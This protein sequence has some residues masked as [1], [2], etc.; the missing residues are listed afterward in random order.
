MGWAPVSQNSDLLEAIMLGTLRI[1]M[2]SSLVQSFYLSHLPVGT[3]VFPFL[4]LGFYKQRAG[5]KFSRSTAL[6]I[7]AFSCFGSLF[8]VQTIFFRMYGMSY[9]FYLIVLSFIGIRW[10]SQNRAD[11]VIFA[12]VVTALAA[13]YHTLSSYVLVLLTIMLFLQIL[14]RLAISKKILDINIRRTFL[15]I[16]IT[17]F[18]GTYMFIVIIYPFAQVFGFNLLDVFS[19]AVSIPGIQGI[20][21]MN[22][23]FSKLDIISEVSAGIIFFSGL[24][25]GVKAVIHDVNDRD[26]RYLFFIC[27]SLFLFAIL[28]VI[29]LGLIT[30]LA[31]VF[32]AVYPAV[33]LIFSILLLKTSRMSRRLLLAV[34]L[35]C[36][37]VVPSSS[38][39]FNQLEF[40]LSTNTVSSTTFAQIN[41][42]GSMSSQTTAIFTDF[43]SAGSLLY[44]GHVNVFGLSDFDFTPLN[45]TSY[46]NAIYNN[47]G[48]DV[49]SKAVHEISGSNSVLFLYRI[50]EEKGIPVESTVYVPQ[51][52][53]FI[54]EYGTYF[55]LV[56][57]T[58]QSIIFIVS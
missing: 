30:A 9:F 6:I 47:G 56:Y 27:G 2:G 13:S 18:F 33:P 7:L 15:G 19:R 48:K 16:G 46:A 38:I 17:L 41:Y 57:S 25:V 52:K 10:S 32:Q 54:G 45:F 5:S 1:I 36:I 49:I 26:T 28:E 58:G 44:Y 14:L 37:I 31:R 4:I 24:L 35:V 42:V 43:A 55:D 40:G 23:L 3:I 50:E 39:A 21:T 11:L 53:S 20:S 51:N 8:F 34:A 12:I 22:S 29:G